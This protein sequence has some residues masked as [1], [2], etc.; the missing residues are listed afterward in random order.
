VPDARDGG[1][2]DPFDDEAA[3]TRWMT[4][5]ELGQA[6]GISVASA[7]GLAY[8]RKWRRQPGN[9]GT[10]RVAVPVGG[11]NRRS[12]NTQSTRDDVT[13]LVG[14]LEAS[15]STLREQLE[16][17]RRRAD[18]ATEAAERTA[19]RLAE[20]EAKIARLEAA[21]ATAVLVRQSLERALTAEESVSAE[22]ETALALAKAALANS[23][24][25]TAELRRAEQLRA[26]R[27]RLSRLRA[28]WHR[29]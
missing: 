6:R 11:G 3:E 8:R 9:D 20:A 21:T 4:Y 26:A 14:N 29:E 24:A 19:T 1:I 27:G 25:E 16:R 22:A 17:E 12:G 7:R 15:L 18:Q 23:A 28:A 10:T 5:G 2:A 13:R